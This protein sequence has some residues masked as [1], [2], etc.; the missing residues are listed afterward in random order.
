MTVDVLLVA[1]CL[2]VGTDALVALNGTRQ[3]FLD[4]YLIA[5]S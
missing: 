5:K 1:F 3:L 4:D 2:A